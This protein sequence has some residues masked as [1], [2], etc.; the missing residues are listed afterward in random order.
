[1]APLHEY[2]FGGYVD[3][4][5]MHITIVIILFRSYSKTDG[6][7]FFITFTRFN[8]KTTKYCDSDPKEIFSFIFHTSSSKCFLN[9]FDNKILVQIDI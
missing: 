7:N 1:M 4:K 2:T 3:V 6:F 5:R 9:P 8:Q